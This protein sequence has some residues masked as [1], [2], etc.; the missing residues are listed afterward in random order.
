[1]APSIRKKL[2]LTSLTSGGRS[3][4]IVRLRTEATEFF[5]LC[6]IELISY[7]SMRFDILT[8]T[9]IQIMDFCDVTPCNTKVSEYPPASI[10]PKGIY[11][12]YFHE[13]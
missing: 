3:A 12:E 9:D 4:G 6:Y 13:V 5:L 11:T 7:I 2:A 8:V 1:V 10:F